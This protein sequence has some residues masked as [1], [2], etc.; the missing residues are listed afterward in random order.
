[1]GVTMSRTKNAVDKQK[2]KQE[3][4]V[5]NTL[6]YFKRHHPELNDEQLEIKA[7]WK[8][9]DCIRRIPESKVLGK[10]FV[11]LPTPRSRV[12]QKRPIPAEKGKFS[13][14]WY[15][16]RVSQLMIIL[17]KEDISEGKGSEYLPLVSSF[18]EAKSQRFV[19]RVLK[20]V[21]CR[22]MEKENEEKAQKRPFKTEKEIKERLRQLG[23]TVSD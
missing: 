6:G 1:M 5:R 15:R 22:M 14:H 19:K 13:P 10:R 2:R 4:K 8:Q 18:G 17:F 7:L 20:R 9:L 23:C 3:T 21:V 12:V 16:Y 11:Y